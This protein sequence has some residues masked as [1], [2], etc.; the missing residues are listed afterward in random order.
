MVQ[1][2]RYRPVCRARRLCGLPDFAVRVP[3]V[4]SDRGGDGRHRVQPGGRMQL[5]L[6]TAA[7][8]GGPGDV[9]GRREGHPSRV[10]A[11]FASGRTAWRGGIRRDARVRQG[12]DPFGQVGP[13]EHHDRHHR[14]GLFD[15][16]LHPPDGRNRAG[17]DLGGEQEAGHG[18]CAAD[19]GPR[20]QV[21]VAARRL[22]GRKRPG[23]L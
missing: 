23:C 21:H 5:E 15:A 13:H 10:G 1:I 17:R 22:S 20:G 9:R 14:G 8:A 19:E 7:A 18:G 2:C 3:S 16:G 11:V 12:T 4:Q 6:A